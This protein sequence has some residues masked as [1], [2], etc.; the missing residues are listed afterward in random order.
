MAS[1]GHLVSVYYHSRKGPTVWRRWCPSP[2]CAGS[3]VI[4]G[5][6]PHTQGVQWMVPMA[7]VPSACQSSKVTARKAQRMAPLVP[8]PLVPSLHTTAPAIAGLVGHTSASS[9]YLSHIRQ[10]FCKTVYRPRKL[11][12]T[13]CG[14][15]IYS[16]PSPVLPSPL[17]AFLW[18][19]VCPAP[20]ALRGPCFSFV[21]CLLCPSPFCWST[22]GA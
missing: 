11:H 12:N 1:R 8:V 14:K 20:L 19:P 3:T 16:L 6:P 21:G 5:T 18:Y 22:H 17:L 2:L 9:P 4:S 13:M 7:P 10:D 15:L